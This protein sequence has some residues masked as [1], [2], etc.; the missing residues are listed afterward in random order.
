MPLCP[1]GRARL[2]SLLNANC[3]V[4][5]KALT[6][7][8]KGFSRA[9]QG[10]VC[11]CVCTWVC[12]RGRIYCCHSQRICIERACETHASHQGSLTSFLRHAESLMGVHRPHTICRIMMSAPYTNQGGNRV[13]LCTKSHSSRLNVW[14]VLRSSCQ[15]VFSRVTVWKE[16][17]TG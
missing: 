6:C 12:M 11:M 15:E 5:W 10:C 7:S 17:R 13:W 1:D 14:H 2:E 4:Y 9:C 3:L 16:V 8:Q